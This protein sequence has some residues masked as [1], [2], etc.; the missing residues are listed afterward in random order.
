MKLFRSNIK[1]SP[2]TDV[3][4]GKIAGSILKSQRY[5]DRLLSGWTKDW[6]TKKK[7]VFLA[8]VCFIFGGLSL[9]ALLRPFHVQRS[10]GL[11]P[12]QIVTPHLTHPKSNMRSISDGEF[13]AVQKYKLDHP[14]LKKER[15]SLLDSLNLIEKIYHSQKK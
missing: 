8:I 13:E 1:N 11:K 6:G 12:A 14:D 15:P 9:N 2:L 3:A 4:A 5:F 10:N 7:W